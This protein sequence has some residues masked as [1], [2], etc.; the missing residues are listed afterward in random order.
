M[1]ARNKQMEGDAARDGVASSS[2]SIGIFSDSFNRRRRLASPMNRMESWQFVNNL[3][4]SHRNPPVITI[5]ENEGCKE[6]R[7]FVL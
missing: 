2:L 5:Y 4:V 7:E 3:N 1:A 6:V